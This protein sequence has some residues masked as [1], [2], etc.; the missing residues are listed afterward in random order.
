MR[1]DP[2]ENGVSRPLSGND[3]DRFRKESWP[4]RNRKEEQRPIHMT[5]VCRRQ[6]SREGMG[7]PP[8]N[9]NASRRGFFFLIKS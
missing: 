4:E 3:R 6:K 1:S 7:P 9:A 5:P 8:P 2:R